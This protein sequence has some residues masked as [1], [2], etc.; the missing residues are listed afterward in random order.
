M[1][2]PQAEECWDYGA[3][4]EKIED[5]KN[6]TKQGIHANFLESVTQRMFEDKLSLEYPTQSEAW[7]TAY[8]PV[9]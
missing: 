9:W 8:N 6:F 2:F 5:N 4:I 3:G 1:V 7:K